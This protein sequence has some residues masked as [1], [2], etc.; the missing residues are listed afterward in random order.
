MKYKVQTALGISKVNYQHSRIDPIYGAGQGTRYSSTNWIFYSTP[1]I[2]AIDKHWEG[3]TIS[4]PN[5]DITY[6]KHVLGF[7][8]DKTQYTNDWEN[9]DITKI[10]KNIQHAAQSWEELLHTSGGK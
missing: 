3:C 4:N 8:D 2:K 10:T 7:L 5:K 6:T 9:N 1:M